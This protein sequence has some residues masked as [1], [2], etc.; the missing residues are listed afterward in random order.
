M[1]FRRFGPTHRADDRIDNFAPQEWHDAEYRDVYEAFVHTDWSNRLG[2][3]LDEWPDTLRI[4]VYHL[5]ATD[6][7]ASIHWGREKVQIYNAALK[8]HIAR[9]LH[10]ALM[11]SPWLETWSSRIPFSDRIFAE[12]IETLETG[13]GEFHKELTVCLTIGQIE[14]EEKI[15]N[16]STVPI[17]SPCGKVHG[18]FVRLEDRTDF[19]VTQRIEKSLDTF[20]E[21]VAH[22][23]SSSDLY[24]A[25]KQAAND[26]PRDVPCLAGYFCDQLWTGLNFRTFSRVV[27]I[28]V[29][30]Q[31]LPGS[32]CIQS[33]ESW[34][35]LPLPE[36]TIEYYIMEVLVT[37]KSVR[38]T[39]SGIISRFC[40]RRAFGDVT[41]TVIVYPL[42][43]FGQDVPVGIVLQGLNPRRNQADESVV[44]RF[45]GKM[46]AAIEVLRKHS[47]ASEQLHARTAELEASQ[48][49]F[50]VM[51]R[52][53]PAGIF[54]L[55]LRTQEYEFANDAYYEMTGIPKELGPSV[56]P[57]YIHPD[58]RE[59]GKQLW[60]DAVKLPITNF[61]SVSQL[62]QHKAQSAD[63]TRDGS[64]TGKAGLRDGLLAI[65][66]YIRMLVVI[67]MSLEHSP[68][69]QLCGTP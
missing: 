21:A 37:G 6:T 30:E 29:F 60:S 44:N 56:W 3:P 24:V 50:E 18:I 4:M 2:M 62:L 69:R 7:P 57:E 46:G 55:N 58:Q 20:Q 5:F 41:K 54:V 22:A 68:T 64:R 53:C 51:M 61:E 36:R 25:F 45:D 47:A 40:E 16:S 28:G 11:G 66:C 26:L 48:R 43:C 15:Y 23:A 35:A 19:V 65:P 42:Y 13:K 8:Q 1:V 10:P 27:G 14:N 32:L 12:Y 34:R 17:R 33:A 49:K 9:D 39:D 63:L 38:L 52:A 67:D 59:A 31:N